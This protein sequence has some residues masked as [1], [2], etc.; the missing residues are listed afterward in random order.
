MIASKYSTTNLTQLV[1]EINILLLLDIRFHFHKIPIVFISGN[2][3]TINIEYKAFSLIEVGSSYYVP[4]ERI[5][6]DIGRN[7]K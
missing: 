2:M 1:F 3:V 4:I 6:N 5:L 7:G